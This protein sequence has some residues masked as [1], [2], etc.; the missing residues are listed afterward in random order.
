MGLLY[1]SLLDTRK[2]Q[3]TEAAK[4]ETTTNAPVESSNRDDLLSHVKSLQDNNQKLKK[5]LAE[6]TERNG[7]LSQKTREGMQSAL[8]T[9]MKK[10]MDSCETKD[11][12]VKDEF[13]SGMDRLVKNS[14]EDNGV[15]QM[16]VAA[17]A[18]HERQTHDLD[19]LRAENSELKT[20]VTGLYSEE[21]QRTAVGEKRRAENEL[22]PPGEG[23]ER[24]TWDAFATEIGKNDW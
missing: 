6:A 12:K 21:G 23:P 2:M 14:A 8:D 17:S 3:S 19:T 13:K 16:M 20:R 4:S 5:E 15:W 9:L 24:F 18:L 11:D 1:L 22:A 7:R 10:W